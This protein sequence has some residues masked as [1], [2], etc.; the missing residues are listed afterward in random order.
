MRRC[1]ACRRPAARGG[2]ELRALV[3]D[4][5]ERV[6]RRER[7]EE[8]PAERRLSRARSAFSP[9]SWVGK[10][11]RA[12]CRAHRRARRAARRSPP[13][14]SPGRASGRGARSGS[15]ARAPTGGGRRP[16]RAHPPARASGSPPVRSPSR[17]RRTTAGGRPRERAAAAASAGAGRL[18]TA[19]ILESADGRP[20]PPLSRQPRRHGLVERASASAQGRRRASAR[21]PPPAVA[22]RRARRRA[23]TSRGKSLARRQLAQWR[24]LA[25]YLPK[26]DIFHFYFGQT[27]VP[28]TFQFPILKRHRGRSA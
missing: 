20:G 27:L 2:L 12:A 7:V 11:G 5:L 22:A 6:P 23:S 16:G 17:R 10:I 18:F 26:T 24:A 21:L 4:P 9:S 15:G 1:R 3:L 8:P 19:P 13:R 25:R 28:K 14:P